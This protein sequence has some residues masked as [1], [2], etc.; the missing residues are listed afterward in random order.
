MVQGHVANLVCDSVPGPVLVPH[1]RTHLH[2]R[3]SLSHQTG[4]PWILTAPEAL[5]HPHIAA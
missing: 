4:F 3:V 5:D 1:A 2:G